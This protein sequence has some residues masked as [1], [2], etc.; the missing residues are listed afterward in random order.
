[1]A[2]FRG[3]SKTDVIL[4][5]AKAGRGTVRRPMASLLLTGLPAR[6]AAPDPHIRRTD[7]RVS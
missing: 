1:V 4:S 5:S 7:L 6:H 3:D 2:Q